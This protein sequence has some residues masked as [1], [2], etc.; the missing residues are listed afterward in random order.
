VQPSGMYFQFD[1]R[2]LDQLAERHS[3]Q[4]ASAEP[5]PH[6]V[7]DDFVPATVLD[8]VLAEFPEPASNQ[9]RRYSRIE[10]RKLAWA[11]DNTMGLVTRHVLGQFNS[12]IFVTFLERL[13]GIRGIVPDP[14]FVGGGLHQIQRGGFLKV[15]ADFNVHP[16]LRLDR[17][18]NLLLYLNR[19][20]R[21]EYGGAL[22]LWDRTMTHA[23]RAIQPIFNRCVIFATTSYSFH[24]HPDPLMC[25]EDITR[26]SLAFY[27][28]TNGRPS[29]A[30]LTGG[31]STLFR[32]RPGEA[33]RP[34][35]Q[36]IINFAVH[37]VLPPLLVDWIRELRAR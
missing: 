17:R 25:P 11:D 26:R 9:W 20:W 24:G 32:R 27:Y 10:E 21:N 5:F 16:R 8:Q 7:L 28:Y 18:L 31:H 13:T 30:F 22:E 19:D 15:H 33:W 29:E 3:K 14:H 36:S 23:V 12:S 34:S 37:R 35:A 1:G 6:V 4:F 2:E